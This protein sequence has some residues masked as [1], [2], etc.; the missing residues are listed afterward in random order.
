[1][2]RKGYTAE[3]IVDKF[4]QA[5]YKLTK[6]STDGEMSKKLGVFEQSYYKWCREYGGMRTDPGQ[7]SQGT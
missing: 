3:Q 6:R 7:T 4:R 1:M 2:G 5:E